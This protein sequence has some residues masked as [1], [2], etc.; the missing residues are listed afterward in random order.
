MCGAFGTFAHQAYTA[1][2]RGQLSSNV[3][4]R[5]SR[6]CS[7]SAIPAPV[8]VSRAATTRL[9]REMRASLCAV[10][11]VSFGSR[12]SVRAQAREVGLAREKKQCCCAVW[13]R[14]W[15]DDN[16]SWLSGRLVPYSRLKDGSQFVEPP[17][18]LLARHGAGKYRGGRNAASAAVCSAQ[19]GALPHVSA[20]GVIRPLQSRRIQAT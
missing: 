2:L 11:V 13:R 5:S 18:G 20:T 3:R 17:R 15:P 7:P 10:P 12:V 1:R 9:R 19:R 6:P 8:G 14:G 4:R 16:G